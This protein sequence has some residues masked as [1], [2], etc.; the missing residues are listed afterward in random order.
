M[1]SRHTAPTGPV[2]PP[3]RREVLTAL[4]VAGLAA[5][6]AGLLAGCGDDSKKALDVDPVELWQS[7]YDWNRVLSDPRGRKYYLPDWQLSSKVGIDVSDYSGEV[8]WP[9]VLADGIEFAFLRAGYRGYGSG[10]LVAD[11]QFAANLENARAA[12]MPI[13]AYFF[14]SA[15]SEA[16]AVEEAE[17]VIDALDGME[18]E[19]PIVYD[20]EKVSD[21]A[22]R[23][24]NLT[25]TQYTANARAF[26]ERV[27]EA[28]YQAMVYGNQHQ[29]ALMDLN[30]LAD[31]PLWYAEY[32][33][34]QPSAEVNFTMWQYAT[35]G[36]VSGIDDGVD[37]TIQFL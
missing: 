8:D 22:G 26:C 18:L 24:N 25:A 15:V 37:L 35:D 33:V 9:S 7:P 11:E 13:G 23:A 17:F 1:P 5:G 34:S 4:G 28:G 36:V 32:G 29:L 10:A 16:E 27:V 2:R 21:A 3:T 31:Y 6:A 14:S 19:Y 12:Q 20:Q 30:A